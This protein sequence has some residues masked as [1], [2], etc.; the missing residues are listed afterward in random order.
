MSNWKLETHLTLLPIPS[1]KNKVIT[2]KY[3]SKSKDI[4]VNFLP[5]SII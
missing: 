3:V 5:A 2:D 4:Q 1:L